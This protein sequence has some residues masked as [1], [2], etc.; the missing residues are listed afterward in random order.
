M[1]E[2]LYRHVPIS[3]CCPTHHVVLRGGVVFVYKSNCR[4]GLFRNA[5]SYPFMSK[6][7]TNVCFPRSFIKTQRM[8]ANKEERYG[9]ALFLLRKGKH[10][11][12]ITVWGE[13]IGHNLLK[14]CFHTILKGTPSSILFF[15][16]FCWTPAFWRQRRRLQ[17]PPLRLESSRLT[18]NWLPT[19]Q[20]VFMMSIILCI[21][22]ADL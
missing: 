6:D 12:L 14:Q 5:Y 8:D 17:P 15:A 20:A 11:K 13:A 19:A 2:E 1:V 18:M 9:F 22:M 3:T 16:G 7:L 10:T 4:S 21:R